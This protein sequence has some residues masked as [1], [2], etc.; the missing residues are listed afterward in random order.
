MRKNYIGLGDVDVIGNTNK[1]ISRVRY[2]RS[3][4]GVRRIGIKME[5]IS[6]STQFHY[7]LEQFN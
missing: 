5:R 1:S 7:K 2:D 3:L 6:D 4:L